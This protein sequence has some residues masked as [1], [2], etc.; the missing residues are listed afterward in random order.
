MWFVRFSFKEK[1]SLQNAVVFPLLRARAGKSGNRVLFACEFAE[2]PE[3]NFC[4]SSF[5]V[6]REIAFHHPFVVAWLFFKN[7]Y[8]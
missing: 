5:G 6:L 3:L 2:C 4:K 7:F 1:K 8:Y